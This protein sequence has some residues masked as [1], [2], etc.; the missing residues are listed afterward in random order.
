[1]SLSILEIILLCF[2]MLLIGL[3]IARYTMKNKYK[4]IKKVGNL[5]INMSDPEKD[6]YS[7]EL[8]IPF[9][10]LDQHSKVIFEIVHT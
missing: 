8:D 9:G 7:L 5:V 10:E 2:V 1:M 4:E 3:I 6:V